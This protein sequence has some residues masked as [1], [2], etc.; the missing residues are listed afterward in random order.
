MNQKVLKIITVLMLIATLTMANFV[1]LCADVVSYAI[2]AVNTEKSTNN[3]NVEFVAYLKNEN[4]EKV[5][6][7]DAKMNAEDLKLYFQITVKQ[8]GLFNG[9]IV[10]SD[11]NFKFKTDFSDNSINRIEE[12]KIYLNQINAGETKEIEVGIQL[13]TDSK[14]DLDLISKESKIAI[15]GTYKDSTQKDIAISATRMIKINMVSPYSSAEECIKLSQEIITNKIAK[16][17]GED[18]RIIQVQ[19]NS[20]INNNLV[21]IKSSLIKVLVFKFKLL[22]FQINIQRF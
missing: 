3:K 17:N 18:K 15:E 13:L 10:L 20:G 1:L 8:E 9:N 19:V 22:K 14:F 6:S 4:G 11:A 21:P 2:D 5:N 16:Y 7:L 12:N